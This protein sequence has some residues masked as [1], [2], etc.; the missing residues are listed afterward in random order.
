MCGTVGMNDEIRASMRDVADS[1][2]QIFSTVLRFGP[3][4]R[5]AVRATLVEAR[6]SVNDKVR[7][8]LSP[9]CGRADVTGSFDVSDRRC[10]LV[11][12]SKINGHTRMRQ[13]RA[14]NPTS[15]RRTP[16]RDSEINGNARMRRDRADS[17]TSQ[18][19]RESMSKDDRRRATRDVGCRKNEKAEEFSDM[20]V[21][22]CDE[23]VHSLPEKAEECS[24]MAVFSCDELVHNLPYADSFDR[25]QMFI[26]M[27]GEC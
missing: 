20:A 23:L 24:D 4:E 21:I 18:Q 11:R 10:S 12:D 2:R 22:S 13:D 6:H 8:T 16:V 14:K 1:M 9:R 25:E 19:G 5:D 7:A 3:D 27:Q 26:Y 17:H 15:R